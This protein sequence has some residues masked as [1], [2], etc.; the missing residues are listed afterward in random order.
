MSTKRILWITLAA[1]V[2]AAGAWT[3]RTVWRARQ[4]IVSLHVRNAPVAEVVRS[5]ARQSHE[6]IVAGKDLTGSITLDLDGVRLTEA[7]ASVAEQAGGLPGAIHT[8]YRSERE[9]EKLKARLAEG[10]SPVP[11]T[12]TNLAP[13]FH[14]PP[15]D[16]DGE[17]LAGAGSGAIS[18]SGGPRVQVLGSG[19]LPPEVMASL[20]DALKSAEADGKPRRAMTIQVNGRE[21]KGLPEGDVALAVPG[22][23]APVN[24]KAQGATWTTSGGSGSRQARVMTL[25]LEGTHLKDGDLDRALKEQLGT[26]S[27]V[28][29]E[30][31]ASAVAGALG[32]LTNGTLPAAG[33]RVRT[34]SS[35]PMVTMHRSGA[36]ADG[37]DETTFWSPERIILETTLMP[38]LGKDLPES[39]TRAEADA[40]AG[41]V[42]GRCVTL[43][44]LQP[45]QAGPL[46]ADVL[47]QMR[48]M[49]GGGRA[50]RL[51]PGTN[52]AP[53]LERLTSEVENR[54]QRESLEQFQK[55][56]PEQR[57]E[58]AR[59]R[60]D[61][62]TNR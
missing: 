34:F 27:G 19:E 29:A 20:G 37:E 25:R 18:V 21:L 45:S 43:Y 35:G 6:T 57:A 28:V 15:P 42:Q 55:L 16:M 4:D 14:F 12:W 32:D 33:T 61:S 9:L 49:L 7:L 5:L 56:T 44:A 59:A 3:A 46:P 1:A 31:V 52:G 39:P 38:R 30:A 13:N 10:R 53:N 8:V 24:A 26:N 41:K 58:R 50:V 54:I 2:V 47:R 62:Q 17:E 48:P 22:S 11:E 23:N 36:S 40:V 51:A 60:R